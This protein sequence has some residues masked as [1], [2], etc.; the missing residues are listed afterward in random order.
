MSSYRSSSMSSLPGGKK[1]AAFLQGLK[2]NK[3]NRRNQRNARV[4]AR[5]AV[6]NDN[7]LRLDN[8]P[9][10][11]APK[12]KRPMII[13]DDNSSK[14]ASKTAEYRSVMAR[15]KTQYKK[16]WPRVKVRMQSKRP[17]VGKETKNREGRVYLT[18]LNEDV[19][20]RPIP[21][22]PQWDVT[23]LSSLLKY[24]SRTVDDF[25]ANFEKSFNQ[26]IP[27]AKASKWLQGTWSDADPVGRTYPNGVY[28]IP[29]AETDVDHLKFF[30]ALLITL[31]TPPKNNVDRLMDKGYWWTP[32]FV[33]MLGNTVQRRDFMQV[34][35]DNITDEIDA[36]STV[37][38][39]F[40]PMS[41]SSSSTMLYLPSGRST[42]SRRVS[43]QIPESRRKKLDKYAR[44][45]LYAVDKL[46]V[47]P[48]DVYYFEPKFVAAASTVREFLDNLAEAND[49]VSTLNP[50]RRKVPKAVKALLDT[51]AV[52]DDRF[53]SDRMI[54]Q[55]SGENRKSRSRNSSAKSE[56]DLDD[57]FKSKQRCSTLLRARY[58]IVTPTDYRRFMLKCHPDKKVNGKYG[59]SCTKNV[60]GKRL[61]VDDSD[62]RAINYCA[63]ALKN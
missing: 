9:A 16:L 49:A 50:S 34:V 32:N 27:S 31:S 14:P 47:D 24:H 44:M 46:D 54:A 63:R 5:E 7:V 56:V 2:A 38:L 58:E 11:F 23:P 10:T 43:K 39:G 59:S 17:A 33:Q 15:I 41:R 3:E 40:K 55:T 13:D 29:V 6:R 35:L 52:Q 45:I 22:G 28:G 62:I 18:W 30:Y 36:N 26:K 1:R 48:R 25:R 60:K 8:K 51:E 61:T 20:E 57:S 53:D 12:K 42:S 37:E 21:G 4:Q 19:F